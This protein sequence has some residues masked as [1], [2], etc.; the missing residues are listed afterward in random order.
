[1]NQIRSFY[2]DDN[3]EWIS[4][5]IFL[6]LGFLLE[7]VSLSLLIATVIL[8]IEYDYVYSIVAGIIH[9]IT[10]YIGNFFIY[11]AFFH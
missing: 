1:M 7:I 10:N 4:L 9:L 5:Y 8:A 3:F 2:K 6:I 11:G